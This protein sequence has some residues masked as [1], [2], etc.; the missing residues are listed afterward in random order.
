M[1]NTLV[2]LK[3]KSNQKGS[4]KSGLRNWGG[5]GGGE[6]GMGGEAGG[7]GGIPGFKVNVACTISTWY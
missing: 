6:R 5:W 3:M 1:N 4:D 7:G 2:A